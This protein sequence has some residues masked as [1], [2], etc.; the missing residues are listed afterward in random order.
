M[1]LTVTITLDVIFDS[2]SRL[3]KRNLRK[4]GTEN[5]DNKANKRKQTSGPALVFKLKEEDINT[6][7]QAIR[8]VSHFLFTIVSFLTCKKKGASIIFITHLT[9]IFTTTEKKS[10]NQ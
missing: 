2:Q 5:S 10:Y 4:R 8:D 9:F 6:D 7:I 1:L 3:H